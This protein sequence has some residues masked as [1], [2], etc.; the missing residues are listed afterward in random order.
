MRKMVLRVRC[1]LRWIKCECVDS[2]INICVN[3]M[4]NIHGGVVM[5][6]VQVTNVL[7][8][9]VYI[10]VVAAIIREFLYSSSVVSYF[11]VIVVVCVGIGIFL[12][13]PG[14]E[15]NKE[16]TTEELIESVNSGELIMVP[17]DIVR[18]VNG[19]YVV[20]KDDNTYEELSDIEY[21]DDDGN[22]YIKSPNKESDSEKA[23]EK[24]YV[25]GGKH[26]VDAG[27]GTLR[28]VQIQTAS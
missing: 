26:Y 24:V 2:D 8:A 16:Y 5:D 19:D 7:Y 10:V 27:D 1:E 20:E 9:V 4:T 14:D 13:Y 18:K 22:V 23:E 15:Y 12:N 6:L 3:G 11:A 25:L 21:V 17:N 28:E